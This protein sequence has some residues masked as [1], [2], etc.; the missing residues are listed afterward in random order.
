MIGLNI[1]ELRRERQI[2]FGL[3]ETSCRYFKPARDHQKI[4]IICCI[5]ALEKKTVLLKYTIG[6]SENNVLLVEGFE[7]RIC[8]DVSALEDFRAIN[9]PEDIYDVLN[10]AKQQKEEST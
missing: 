1:E 5:E 6:D 8:L 10:M 7:K 2:S 3:V 9:I 4:S